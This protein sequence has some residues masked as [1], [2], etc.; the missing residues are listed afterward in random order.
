MPGLLPAGYLGTNDF[1]PTCQ[2]VRLPAACSCR[3][4]QF[5][6]VSAN[7]CP[8]WGGRTRR[9]PVAS[10][11][12]PPASSAHNT[13]ERLLTTVMPIC[14]LQGPPKL[15]HHE[16]WWRRTVSAATAAAPTSR[17]APVLPLL[18]L[19]VAGPHLTPVVRRLSL[20]AHPLPICQPAHYCP[21][22]QAHNLAAGWHWRA[23]GCA[24]AN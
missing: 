15:A 23:A 21:C 9:R 18:P 16:G 7:W 10:C 14:C 13:V 24:C 5:W 12:L 11:Q 8:P 1:T 2:C 17:G 22:S 20:A 4:V 3:L 19:A 6:A